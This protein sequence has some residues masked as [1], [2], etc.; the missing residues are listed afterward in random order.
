LALYK[1]WHQVVY[2]RLCFS[3][4]QHKLVNNSWHDVWVGYLQSFHIGQ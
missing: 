1:L 2:I 3:S 4:R